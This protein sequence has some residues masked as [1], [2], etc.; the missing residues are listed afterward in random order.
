MRRKIV[1][2]VVVAV[3]LAVFAGVALTGA[4]S[5]PARAA[6]KL[7][8]ITSIE[9]LTDM[10]ANLPKLQSVSGDFTWSTTLLGS[11]PVVLGADVPDEVQ[12]FLPSGSGTV[13]FQKD[14]VRLEAKAGASEATVVKSGSHVWVWTSQ[15]GIATDY[16]LPPDAACPRE[17][18]QPRMVTAAMI[19]AAI[20]RMAPVAT[21]SVSGEDTVAGRQ[22]YLLT[23]TPAA[24][25]SSFDHADV[26]IDASTY[27]PLR[28][29]VFAAGVTEPVAAAG[30]T[31]IFYDPIAADEFAFTPPAGAKVRHETVRPS[32]RHGMKGMQEGWMG[33]PR[34]HKMRG[35]W[36]RDPS[37]AI[38]RR[39]MRELS[40][41]K[42]RRASGLDLLAAPGVVRGL[43]F[44]GAH[45]MPAHKRG[46]AVAVLRYGDGFRTVVLAEGRLTKAQSAQVRR[47][48]A[49]VSFVKMAK[50][51]GG[52]GYLY[53]S[54][55]FNVFVWR[56]GSLTLVA[57]GAVPLSDLQ[58]FVA[59]LR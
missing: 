1:I 2:A 37:T 17:Q 6:V 20:A 28:L 49:G 31:S 9:L 52:R 33:G 39:M 26:A 30:F 15:S 10:V 58:A 50:I 18:A 38:M 23:L 46:G 4:K 55:L 41:A 29:R 16:R 43:A 8:T 44:R 12:G 53:S 32:P 21:L 11:A 36:Q 47:H 14:D 3:L 22:A 34:M 42:A 51:G 40:V 48:L 57:G 5:T 45:V 13:R 25:G 35:G 56:H 54:P 59:A 24:S 7:P 27:L 19:A